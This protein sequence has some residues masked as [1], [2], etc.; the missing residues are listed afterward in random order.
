MGEEA[1]FWDHLEVLRGDLIRIVV[2]VLV[3]GV[4]AFALRDPL[5]RLVLAP[6]HSDFCLWRWI[7]AAPFELRLV[8]TDLAE[9]MMIHLRVAAIAGMLIASP[10]VL[11]VLFGFVAPALYENE[12]RH[13]TGI[14]AAAYILFMAGVALNYLLI[15][16]LT[17]RFLGTYQVSAEVGNMLTIRSYID[18]LVMMT[19][20]FGIICEMPVLS[21]ILARIG[22]LRAEWMARYR[23][24][25][26][27]A[28]L[29]LAAILTPTTDI[30]TLVIVALPIWILYEISIQIVKG[31]SKNP[32]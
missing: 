15:F 16:P 26:I 29:T 3:A 10:Y 1:S 18:T 28:I 23:R 17:V 12:R 2:A 30:F 25:A 13:T 22:I 19:W 31:C 32:C 11:Y 5:F 6:T 20:V 8:N 27:V 7:G 14:L 9:Q 4:V 24:H 21:G